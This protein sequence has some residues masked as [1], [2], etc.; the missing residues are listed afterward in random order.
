MV[1][2]EKRDVWRE[3]LSAMKASLESTYEFKTVVHEE[4]RLIQ[5]LKDVKKDYVIFSSY[6]RNAG[7]R[8]MNDIKS[9]IDTALEK[10]N[11]CDSKEASL[12]YLETLKTVMMQTRWASV[13]ETLSEYDHTYGS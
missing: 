11:C 1:S 13:L 10:L 7:K 8:R 12:I 5:G 4:A 2:L 3:S 6:R 9:L